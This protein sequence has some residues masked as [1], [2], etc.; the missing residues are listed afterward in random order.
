MAPMRPGS[1]QPYHGSS[2]PQVCTPPPGRQLH[3]QPGMA[4]SYVRLARSLLQELLRVM[5][6]FPMWLLLLSYARARGCVAAAV[7]EQAL[8]RTALLLLRGCIAVIIVHEVQ[9]SRRRVATR[10]LSNLTPAW[11]LDGL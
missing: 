10:S 5:W 4:L 9:E 7:T 3:P 6:C 11:Q 8:E 2:A 1:L